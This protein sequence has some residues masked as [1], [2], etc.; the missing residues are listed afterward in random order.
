M[1]NQYK[2]SWLILEQKEIS[3][4][5]SLSLVESPR[6][7]SLRIAILRERSSLSNLE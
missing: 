2:L 6:K 7:W 3:E 5:R 4:L 1:Q